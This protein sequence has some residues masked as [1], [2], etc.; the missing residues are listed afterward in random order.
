MAIS[1]CS[2]IFTHNEVLAIYNHWS[3]LFWHHRLC[4]D[5][6]KS[7][8]SS[9]TT[10]PQH[11]GF[12][13]TVPNSINILGSVGFFIGGQRFSLTLPLEPPLI[14]GTVIYLGLHLFFAKDSI[15]MI[16]HI[17]V[18]LITK[19]LNISRDRNQYDCLLSVYMP[20][21]FFSNAEDWVRISST[22]KRDWVFL[23]AS[24][25]RFEPVMKPTPQS[26]KVYSISLTLPSLT[27]YGPPPNHARFCN[28][29]ISR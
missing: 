13:V 22:Q 9:K 26:Y 28:T 15:C 7:L 29:R 6:A 1:G 14:W 20:I 5:N 10:A 11:S 8:V 16:P 4:N 3:Q 21:S 19:L 2:G 12:G 17:L 24:N 18:S 23:A 25:I 27:F